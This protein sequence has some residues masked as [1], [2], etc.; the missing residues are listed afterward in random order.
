[1]P[2][3]VRYVDETICMSRAC[4]GCGRV[5]SGGGSARTVEGRGLSKE[6]SNP[7]PCSGGAEAINP[8]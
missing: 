3:S 7:W 1:M 6:L 2:S 8:G 5:L 4:T